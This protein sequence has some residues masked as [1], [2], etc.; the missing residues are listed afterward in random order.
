M[1]FNK[2]F[3]G[4]FQSI[5][6]FSKNAPLVLLIVWEKA[7]MLF[8]KP[9]LGLQCIPV[10]LFFQ[11]WPPPSGRRE[12][13]GTSDLFFAVKNYH[14]TFGKWSRTINQKPKAKPCTQSSRRTDPTQ[15]PTIEFSKY[16][17]QRSSTFE[18]CSWQAAVATH[19]STFELCKLVEVL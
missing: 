14:I 18:S 3:L 15:S 4:L 1:L 6:F 16:T 19:S 13:P 10:D 11:M 9:F 8:N 17:V 7:F 5:F 12:G 2:P